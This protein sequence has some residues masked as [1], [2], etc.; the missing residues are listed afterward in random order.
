MTVRKHKRI[1]NLPSVNLNVKTLTTEEVNRDIQRRASLVQS[2][3][4]R[5]FNFIKS[6]RK[7]VTF[8]GSARLPQNHPYAVKA[9]RLASR[10]A[11]LG[12]TVLTGGGPGI[13]EA[14]NHGAFQVDENKSLGLT[15][16]LPEE[17]NRNP[18]INHSMDF[19]YFFNRKVCLTFSA[20]AYLYFPGGFGTLDEFF[21]ILTLVQTRKITRI[22]IILVG[23]DF[24]QPLHALMQ[25][26]L[27][28]RYQTISPHDLKLYEILDD[29]EKI[30]E[31]IRNAPIHVGDARK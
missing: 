22:P 14:A 25:Q 24:W 1:V 16:R 17:Q 21:E 18:Y 29:E 6:I 2:E 7:S 30:V 23:T 15:I 3:L 31:I 8:F 10:L 5:G 9:T 12:Y 26:I 28:E 27:L 13:M 11:E 19:F 20:E 4:T